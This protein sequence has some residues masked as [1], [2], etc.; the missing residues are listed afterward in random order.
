[1]YGIGCGFL[2]D[3]IIVVKLYHSPFLIWPHILLVIFFCVSSIKNKNK[4]AFYK[5][6]K[7]N[8]VSLV[9]SFFIVFFV[10][11]I[12]IYMLIYFNAKIEKASFNIYIFFDIPMILLL[13]IIISYSL[14]ENYKFKSK[15][16]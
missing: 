15:N 9:N 10:S 13:F 4:T 16:Q 8:R 11:T 14:F 6:L 7:E 5:A 3:P 2:T 12:L 1:M